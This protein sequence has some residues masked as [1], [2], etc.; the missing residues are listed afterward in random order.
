MRTN[1]TR[2]LTAKTIASL[3]KVSDPTGRGHGRRFYDGTLRGFGCEKFPTG[4][5]VFFLEY[6]LAGK[7]RRASIGDYGSLTPTTARRK[8]E[9]I[10]ANIQDGNDPLIEKAKRR[11]MPTYGQYVEHYMADVER[12]KKD[13]RHDRLYLK[14]TAD[15]WGNKRAGWNNKRLD[16]ITRTDVLRIRTSIVERVLAGRSDE[17]AGHTTANRWL[18][19]V[20][21]C[22]QTAVSEGLIE[23]NP[24][25]AIKPYRERP[26][27]DRTLTQDEL[28]RVLAAIDKEPDPHVRVAFLLL[29]ETGARR[30]EVLR[31]RWE[32][33]DFEGGTWRIPSPKAGHPQVIPLPK[34]AAVMLRTA[35]RIGPYVVPG[36]DPNRPRVDLKKPWERIRKAAEVPD[37]HVHDVRRTFGLAVARRAGLHVASRLL[38]H[39]DVRVTEKVYAPLGLD[40][41]RKAAEAQSATVVELRGKTDAR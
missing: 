37:V 10:L 36:R 11:S 41:L 40:E 34:A 27:R 9:R 21:S 2:K 6:T 18:A 13:A 15:G 1:K 5:V 12:R 35:P 28:G 17:Q 19:S 32:D 25:T 24:A 20:R 30:S 4:R 39:A 7:Q 8:A 16:A 31:A 33:F 22:L 23:N 14:H 38:R 26:P 3:P 29:I